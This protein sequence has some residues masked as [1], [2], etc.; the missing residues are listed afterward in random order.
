MTI[1]R[2]TIVPALLLF[3]A[4][5]CVD[6]EVQNPNQPEAARALATPGDVESLI[7]GTFLQYWNSEWSP[8]GLGPILSVQSFQHSAF[9]ANFGMTQYSA[10]PRAQLDNDPAHNFYGQWAN[11]WTWLYRSIASAR[12]GLIAIESGN[13][14]MAASQELRARAWAKFNQGLAHAALATVFDQAFIVDENTTIDPAQP[15][16]AQPYMAVMDAAM[17]YFDEAIA[18]A[19][20]GS[21]EIPA[22]WFSRTTTSAELVRIIHSYKARYRAAV[23][24]TPAERQA[25]DWNA[26]IADVDAGITDDHYM[27]I[28]GTTPWGQF[29]SG[30]YY[31]QGSYNAQG[32]WTAIWQQLS[33]FVLGMADQS[34]NYQNWLNTPLGDRHPGSGDNRVLIVTPDNRFPQGTTFAEQTAND[35]RYYITAVTTGMHGQ[36]GRGTWRWSWYLNARQ[37]DW[38]TNAADNPE[39][40]W[41][42]KAEMD[43]LKAEGLYYQNNRQG[44]ADL[45]NITRVAAGLNATDAAGT[46]T[47]CVPKLPD[48]SCGGLLEM[49]KW[50]KRNEHMFGGLMTAPWWFDSRGWGDLYRGTQLEFPMPCREAQVLLME[51]YTFG[52]VGGNRASPGSSYNFPGE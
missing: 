14:E 25:V 22:T 27:H 42:P 41:M 24:R 19:G 46:N 20:S 39:Y 8:S 21:F 10:F 51:C 33:Y 29:G 11:P 28:S 1:L 44:A 32:R 43:L 16:E 26:V 47:S 9:P 17:G 48:G 34:G 18:L 4:A 6:L 52:G 36:P 35:G 45:I 23:A 13:V 7:G 40:L 38:M 50:E 49:L 3:G 37:L 15:L 30:Y 31:Q 5:G 12:D 2:K